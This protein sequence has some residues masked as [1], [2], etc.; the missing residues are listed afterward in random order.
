MS[1][2]IFDAIPAAQRD[3]ARTALAAALGG[4]RVDAIAP[5]MGG[6]SGASVFQ[7]VAAGR[8]YVL[9]MEGVPNPLRNPHQYTS[10]RI[11]ADA[12]IAPP[13]RYLDEKARVVVMDFIEDQPLE[14]FP[15]GFTGLAQAAGALLRQVQELPLFPRFVEYP[16]IV[17]RLWAHVCRT[18]LFAEGVLDPYSER[19][20][21][22]RD[23]YASDSEKAVSSPNDF[24][25]RNLLFDG[26]RLWLV[27]WESAYRN[28]PLVDVATAL[29][30][31]AASPE[32][33]DVLLRAWL[34][35]APDR[36]FRERLA[37]TAALVRLYYAGVLFSA[38]AKLPGAKPDND[39]SALSSAEFEQ[40]IRSGRLK[41]E[42]PEASHALGKM[43]LASFLSGAKPPGLP[44]LYMR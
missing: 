5:V 38:S 17:A 24:L 4:A 16:D 27:D 23:I 31:F 32:L 10:M 14:N 19:L 9:R 12:G 13:V 25:P 20:A 18:G 26:Q 30:N 37:L 36:S 1:K 42:S 11:A 39:L 43:F 22:I 6:V 8:R 15:G 29:D 44:P 2:N 33:E 41:R 40:G 21:R 35:C 3:T 7:V 28:D 34:G